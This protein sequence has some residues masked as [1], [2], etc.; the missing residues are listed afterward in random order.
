M[1][2][3]LPLAVLNPFLVLFC[4]LE[5]NATCHS[6]EEK[7]MTKAE[8][9]AP[10]NASSVLPQM[11]QHI[12]QHE[13]SSNESSLKDQHPKDHQHIT[14]SSSV[15]EQA[16]FGNTHSNHQIPNQSSSN[17][18][19]DTPVNH[20]LENH[21]TTITTTSSSSSLLPSENP[22][23]QNLS[24]STPNRDN[25]RNVNTQ[26]LLMLE[27]SLNG[28]KI[29]SENSAKVFLL[30]KSSSSSTLEDGTTSSSSHVGDSDGNGHRTHQD[31]HN[32]HNTNHN[33]SSEMDD[34]RV[35]TP[36]KAS[37]QQHDNNNLND[38]NYPDYSI[39]ST[40]RRIRD[41][42]IICNAPTTTSTVL[43][44][45]T[46]SLAIIHDHPPH[47]TSPAI[48]IQSSRVRDSISSTG[49]TSVPSGG[50]T[51]RRGKTDKNQ[52]VSIVT[53]TQVVENVTP[54]IS[55]SQS[56]QQELITLLH[57]LISEH[58]ID[59]L[60]KLLR[61]EQQK[62]VTS[63]N[64]N[65]Q[66]DSTSNPSNH[67]NETTT[68][69]SS[70]ING[71][72]NNGETNTPP[73]NNEIPSTFTSPTSS[74]HVESAI[75]TS[76]INN[77]SNNKTKNDQNSEQIVP[78]NVD[79]NYVSEQTGRTLLMTAVAHENLK[80]IRLLH[81]EFNANLEYRDKRG[82]SAIFYAC[83]VSPHRTATILHYLISE[84]ACVN[85][86][87]HEG[88]TPFYL[89]MD[90]QNF[91]A[92]S[93][94]FEHGKANVNVQV[95]VDRNTIIHM[96]IK[97]DLITSVHFLVSRCKCDLTIPNI[98]GETPMFI[99]LHHPAILNQI[100][101][102]LMEKNR[103]CLS[104]CEKY[105]VT[106][107]YNLRPLEFTNENNDNCFHICAE[108]GFIDSL[109]E[110]L[111][112][113]PDEVVRRLSSTQNKDGN[114]PLHVAVN[115][116]QPEITFV[117]LFINPDC[118]FIQNNELDSPL[119]IALKQGHFRC[120][121]IL[122]PLAKYLNL[123]NGE[124]QSIQYLVQLFGQ[125]LR[126]QDDTLKNLVEGE[127]YKP[128]SYNFE[129]LLQDF[130]FIGKMKDYLTTIGQ[131]DTLSFFEHIMEYQLTPTISE[132]YELAEKI[133]SN[134]IAEN[135]TH[136]L[137]F[138]K[139]KREEFTQQ[140]KEHSKIFCPAYLFEN[141]LDLV[142]DE[143]RQNLFPKFCSSKLF[144]TWVENKRKID[145]TFYVRFMKKET[146]QS[147]QE[148]EDSSQLN[149]FEDNLEE[150]AEQD[151]T[152]ERKTCSKCGEVLVDFKDP[153]FMK[154]DFDKAL[155]QSMDFTGW[156]Q[157]ESDP[158]TQGKMFVSPK[159]AHIHIES[160]KKMTALRF[161]GQIDHSNH[162]V[163]NTWMDPEYLYMREPSILSSKQIDYVTGRQFASAII[164]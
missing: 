140:W 11:S 145:P 69:S 16:E 162:N 10:S 117:L 129:Q 80:M 78:F 97:K 141:Y 150:N 132:R 30:A 33:T 59:K 50:N 62:A 8:H 68:G 87:D 64:L 19:D 57:R 53:S 144:K 135:A 107:H 99:A 52:Q 67:S 12:Q 40:G 39:T 77:T 34:Q 152:K 124:G 138:I 73:S 25:D 156:S 9:A 104:S 151:N 88:Y 164:Q 63:G 37:Q 79:A 127:F 100:L 98:F 109:G 22:I 72:N 61:E 112:V 84:G 27:Q 114:T 15:N 149:L 26:E 93:V 49:S 130:S 94:L 44:F 101:M 148:K 115:H 65:N 143:L 92:A 105:D 134:F 55:A 85:I 91:Q 38:D 36:I 1:K 20:V 51:A 113:L 82:R 17:H 74:C 42:L 32:N 146:L 128:T 75:S 121:R 102:D 23:T 103:T 89:C 108:F 21:T 31:D 125:E 159:G 86:T 48:S 126:Q 139:S 142:L 3:L 5:T 118:I 2:D 43:P 95:G 6:Q 154:S 83:N 131:Q 41:S 71:S 29:N 147:E 155:D 14:T 136:K 18:D 122:Y 60:E 161:C 160:K 120:A 35:S 81:K 110:L 54:T 13:S 66:M 116:N 96:A 58:Q 4:R 157:I 119:H 70:C 76:N 123:E 137:K 106:A 153:L 133:V 111:S 24:P 46:L 28:M 45:S 158:T 56:K 7:K 90:S 47:S 163:F